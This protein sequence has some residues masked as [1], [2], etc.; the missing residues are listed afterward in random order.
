MKP[1]HFYDELTY[2]LTLSQAK[3]LLTQGVIDEVV[4][5]CFMDRM[6]EKYHPI[7]SQYEGF[8]T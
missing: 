6:N 1:Q 2:Q 3:L 5:L 4:F 7:I 8:I